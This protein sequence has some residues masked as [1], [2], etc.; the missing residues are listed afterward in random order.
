M[1][2]SSLDLLEDIKPISA[3]RA[4][5]AALIRQAANTGRP[6]VI[7]QNGRSAAVLVDVRSY[8]QM[9]DD[10]QLLQEI[11]QSRQEVAAGAVREHSEVMDELRAKLEKLA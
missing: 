7:T 6:V 9:T 10:L 1:V 4:N 3:F 2:T 5:A 11:L 8:Q